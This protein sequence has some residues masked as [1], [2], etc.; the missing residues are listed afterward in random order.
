LRLHRI[1]AVADKS[2]DTQVLLDPLEEQLDRQRPLYK[3]AIVNAGKAVLLV[4]SASVLPDSGSLN[5]LRRKCRGSRKTPLPKRQKTGSVVK[6]DAPNKIFPIF[7]R[8]FV[9]I[10]DAPRETPLKINAFTLALVMQFTGT[11]SLSKML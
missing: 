11:K 6:V 10:K 1:L 8:N 2:F 9:P 5:L 7:C 4:R 3:A